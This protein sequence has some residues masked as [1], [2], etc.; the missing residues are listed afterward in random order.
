MLFRSLL[1]DLIHLE[2]HHRRRLPRAGVEPGEVA[3][4]EGPGLFRVEVAD[5]DPAEVARPVVDVPVVEG[6]LEGVAVEVARPADHGPRVPARRVEHRVEL[7]LEHARRRALGAQAALLF[8]DLDLLA[9]FVVGPAVAGEAVG[10][11]SEPD[12]VVVYAELGRDVSGF[13][14]D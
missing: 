1:G 10:L 3:L 11:D 9:E 14:F 13:S 5:H 6:L 12:R 7:L 8:D 2:R 4:D